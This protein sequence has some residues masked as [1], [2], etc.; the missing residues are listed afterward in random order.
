MFQKVT[1]SRAC[2]WKG[3]IAFIE[4][5]LRAVLPKL[6]VWR[7]SIKEPSRKRPRIVC[8]CF[9]A[10]FV[11]ICLCFGAHF[12][13]VRGVFRTVTLCLWR[14]CNRLLNGEVEE[15]FSLLV[16][17]T[18]E[19]YD[20]PRFTYSK[21]E[22]YSQNA[23]FPL[24]IKTLWNLTVCCF[25]L[26]GDEL[27]DIHG[28]ALSGLSVTE[29]VDIIRDAPTEFLATVRPVTSVRKALQR[30]FREI[31]YADIVH[32]KNG[33]PNGNHR[34]A[35]VSRGADYET[36]DELENGRR[37]PLDLKMTR[38]VREGRVKEEDREGR[39]ERASG[40]FN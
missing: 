8:L 16:P 2:W 40:C 37:F 5:L 25:F 27:L 36:V 12:V 13:F 21:N 1:L 23:F 14:L 17:V 34:I 9:G 24:G 7:C 35:P 30:D 22:Q 28:V 3:E 6:I 29:V 20:Q 32:F 33:A 26:P 31:K 10:N 15:R 39:Q 11:I 4:V 18:L 19:L 38:K